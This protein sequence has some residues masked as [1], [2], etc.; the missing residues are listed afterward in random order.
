MYN[1]NEVEIMYVIYNGKNCKWGGLAE[2]SLC[3]VC[4]FPSDNVYRA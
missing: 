1:V 2:V 3:S 4:I